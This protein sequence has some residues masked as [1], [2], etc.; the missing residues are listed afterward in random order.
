VTYS[1]QN[2]LRTTVS[3]LE[4]IEIDELYVGVSQTGQQF[5][6]PIQAKTGSDKLAA[7]QTRQDISCCR[8]KF[9]SLG[10]RPI[11]AQFMADCVI[12]LM[13]LTIDREELRIM[14]E[15][16]YRLVPS[17][18]ITADDLRLYSLR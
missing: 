7:T 12:A 4:Q 3:G 11:A 15:R 14:Q 17:A 1:L 10:C 2:H 18:E 9:P 16:H 13:E 5:V 8:E 6:V